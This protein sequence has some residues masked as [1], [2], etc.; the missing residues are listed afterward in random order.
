MFCDGQTSGCNPVLLSTHRVCWQECG[1]SVLPLKCCT[2][3]S[4]LHP[5]LF[6]MGVFWAYEKRGFS[7]L[8]PRSK[9]HLRG[10]RAAKVPVSET[11]PACKR[12]VLLL[13]PR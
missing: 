4:L 12:A 13:G 6:S 5:L 1:H 3:G 9:L 2:G 10:R 7:F 11:Q 8:A